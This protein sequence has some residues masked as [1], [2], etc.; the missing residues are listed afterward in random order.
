MKKHMREVHDQPL[1]DDP[2]A[3]FGMRL[4]HKDRE[5]L[6]RGV[7]EG[8]RQNRV[9][10]KEDGIVLQ[11]QDGGRSVK[12]NV[13]TVL[14]NSKEEYHLPRMVGVTLSQQMSY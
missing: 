7:R 14:L 11:Y 3:E 8:V 5:C 6:K 1:I 9:L 13:R 4:K 2:K 10:E 12:K